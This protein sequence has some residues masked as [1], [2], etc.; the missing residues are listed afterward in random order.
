MLEQRGREGGGI[1]VGETGE[2]GAE[3]ELMTHGMASRVQ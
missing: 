2:P 3:G 1:R